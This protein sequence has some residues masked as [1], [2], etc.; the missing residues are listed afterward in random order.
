MFSASRVLV[1]GSVLAAIGCGGS[2]PSGESGAAAPAGTS[3]SADT[4]VDPCTL[5]TKAE[6]DQ[7]LG[8][9][10]TEER[11]ADAN[12]AP[13]LVACRY[14]AP[15]GNGVA[16]LLVMVRT[17]YSDGEAR[18]GFEGTKEV[19]PTEAVSGLGDDAFWLFDQLHVLSGRRALTLSGSVDRSVMQA[20]ARQAVDRLR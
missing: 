11:P 5:V 6:A 9:A 2:Q 4:P 20:L 17:G 13:H 16:V 15:R 18:T 10:S 7:A 12:H 1:I 19:G 14:T 3:A 8:A